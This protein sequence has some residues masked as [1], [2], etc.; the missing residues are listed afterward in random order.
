MQTLSYSCVLDLSHTITP[1]IPTWPGDP[2]VAFESVAEVQQDGYHLRRFAMGEHSATH[3]NAPRS[4]DAAG[5]GIDSYQP[6]S[7]IVPAVVID[8]CRW[9]EADAD[10]A[11]TVEEVLRWESRHGRIAAGSLVLLYTGWQARWRDPVAFLNRDAQGGMH[12]PGFAELTTRFLLERRAV[13]GVGTDAHGVDPG[14]STDFA[15]NRL[16]LV[17]RGIVLENL[18]GLDQLPAVGAML[19]IGILRLQAGSGSPAAVLALVP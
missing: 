11:L 4:F 9:A 8:I 1:D 18:T 7:L 14:Q 19:V 16:V 6:A 17:R 5:D 15:T 2:A 10:F 12:F 13:A 3:M